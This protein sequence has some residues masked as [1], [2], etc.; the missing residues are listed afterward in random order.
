MRSA[1]L[2]AA[3]ALLSPAFAQT[4]P[5]RLLAAD[6]QRCTLGLGV[7][8]RRAWFANLTI[9]DAP[10]LPPGPQSLTLLAVDLGESGTRLSLAIPDR[11]LPT[12]TQANAAGALA[13]VNGGFFTPQGRPRGLRRVA[14]VE[15]VPATDE[16]RAAVG[17]RAQHFS[18][19]R[20]SDDWHDVPDVLEAGPMLVV[21]GEV[22]QHGERQRTIRHPRTALGVREDATL[23]LLTADG[24]TPL[25]AG[26]SLDELGHVMR[27]LGCRDAINLDGGG[28]ST[29]WAL[30]WPGAGIANHPC[31]NKAFDAEGERAVADV[32]LVYAR[33]VI[34]V[35]DDEAVVREG[36]L[37][38]ERD[39]SGNLG[40]AFAWAPAGD[41]VAA[42]FTVAV[43]RAGRYLVQRR[44]V[45]APGLG[46][47]AANWPDA[48]ELAS[49]GADWVTV[50][51]RNHV[52][53]AFQLVVTSVPG[54]PFL[55]DAVRLVEQ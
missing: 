29:L 19:G 12:T 40:G 31:D 15:V 47:A 23:V 35:D 9:V 37:Q 41:A 30:G 48:G 49:D 36:R 27:A 26:L 44:S 33:A 52:V 18:F 3:S 32:V 45:T 4:L 53:G 46:D 24:R 1:I 43:P 13:A 50:G 14:G 8:L 21:G 34:V 55:V 39:G 6:W 22:V 11:L 25:A 42:V 38:R 7:E 51:E 17:W 20:S 2:L 28:S 16:V 5:E 54:R 10:A